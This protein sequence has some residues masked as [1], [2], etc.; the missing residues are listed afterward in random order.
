MNGRVLLEKV[1]LEAQTGKDMKTTNRVVIWRIIVRRAKQINSAPPYT[2][3]YTLDYLPSGSS[4]CR[5]VGMRGR[6]VP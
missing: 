3:D 4:E 5:R 2:L 1:K 6:A